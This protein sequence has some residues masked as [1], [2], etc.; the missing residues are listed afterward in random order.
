VHTSLP[1]AGDHAARPSAGFGALGR[2]AVTLDQPD[3]GP[4]RPADLAS[5]S[6][7]CRRAPAPDGTAPPGASC[8]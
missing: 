3:S 7:R 8:S 2:H 4:A 1:P 5:A 6:P